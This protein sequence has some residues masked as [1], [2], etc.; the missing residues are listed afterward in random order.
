MVD[1]EKIRFNARGMELSDALV[2]YFLE[3]FSKVEHQHLIEWVDVEF[4]QTKFHRGADSDFYV[5]VLI[6]LPKAYIRVKKTGSDI[7]AIVDEI[8]DILV[9]KVQQYFDELAEK[10]AKEKVV[11]VPDYE[12]EK[13]Y[14]PQYLDYKA[15]VRRKEL[16]EMTPI[17]V[18]EAVAHLE[19]LDLPAYIFRNVDENNQIQM[20][21]KDG[22]EYVLVVP[23][24]G[25]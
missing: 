19:L 24:A 7:Y 18:Q 17:S 11:V 2:D 8:S 23:P 20:I 15:K 5:R 1:S 14:S 6:K 9:S 12:R 10:P 13:L 21:Y 16:Q 22:D 4:A 25:F 3:K